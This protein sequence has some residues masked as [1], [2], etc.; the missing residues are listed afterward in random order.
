MS[1]A[2]VGI[3]G[4]EVTLSS[5]QRL[6][7][8]RA[9]ECTVCLDPEDVGI[10]R[11]AGTIEFDRGGWWVANN[12]ASRPLSIVDDLGLRSVLPPRRR[13]SLEAPAQIIVDGQKGRHTVR[14]VVEHDWAEPQDATLP[15]GAST[16]VGAEVLV[17]DL[18]RLAMV[19]LFAGYL[20]DTPR[21]DPHPKSYAAAAARLGWKRTTLIKRIEYLRVRLD[22]A[23][24]PNMMGFSA[25]RNLAEYAISRGL[26]TRAD[27][28]MLQR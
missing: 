4:D 2:R 22:A 6:T 24:V 28:I 7:F 25:L 10:S 11:V 3:D 26:V 9:R 16:A 15:A 21:Y 1:M 8:G 27:L 17:S 13:A 5:G 12:S 18:D 19:A 20:E 23:G 14:V